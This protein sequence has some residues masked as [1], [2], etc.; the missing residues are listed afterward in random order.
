MNGLKRFLQLITC[1]LLLMVVAINKEGRVFNRPVDEL[2]KKEQ[3]EQ[4]DEWVTADGTR[5]ISTRTMGK[6]IF[7]YAGNTPVQ[8]SLKDGRIQKIELL[9]NSESPD[10]LASVLNSGLLTAWDGLTPAEAIALTVDAT[11]GA[12]LSSSAII[13][14]VNHALRYATDTAPAGSA[15][16]FKW[17]DLRFWAVLVL[18]TGAMVLPL[19]YKNKRYRMVQLVLNVVVLGFWSGSF[20]SLSL[21]VNFF[22]N[23]LN[24]W[25]SVVPVLLLITAF[26][27]P[28]FGKKNHYCTW[29]CPMGSCQE[30]LGKTN[31]YKLKLTQKQLKYLDYF[32][33][34]LWFLIMGVMWAG[35]GFEV[36]D[37]E[38]FTAFLFTSASVP[39][40]IGAVIFA[41]LSC[42]VQ[43]PYCRFVCP[44]GSL[45]KFTQQTK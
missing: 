2:F 14:N 3:K 12:T 35:I 22:S 44:T 20:I 4:A 19:F 45:L 32:R 34:G 15:S 18:V 30:L 1:I 41:L 21:L 38:L 33:E 42:V 31:F 13:E 28:L 7:G 24:I 16:S 29:V 36:L 25:L 9:Q 5:V 17:H 43:R 10:F 27:Y 37:Y 39:I 26:I 6:G 40:I 23:G 11:T 8:I